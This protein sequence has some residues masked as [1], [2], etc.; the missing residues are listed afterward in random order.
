MTSKNM[1]MKQVSIST[2]KK[3]GPPNQYPENI[4]FHKNQTQ[5]KAYRKSQT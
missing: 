4:C 3:H 2:N 1:F 5:T